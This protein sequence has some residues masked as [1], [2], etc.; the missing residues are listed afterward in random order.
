M[1][2]NITAIKLYSSLTD[3]V[4]ATSSNIRSKLSELGV[5]SFYLP[6]AID[7]EFYKPKSVKRLRARLN[8]KEDDI[9]LLYIGNITP[10]RFPSN[11]VLKAVKMLIKQGINIKF[12]I[13]A[14]CLSYNY[15][16]RNILFEKIRNF[17]LEQHVYFSIED[18]TEEEKANIYNIADIFI[19]PSLKPQAIDPPITVLEAMSCGKIVIASPIQSLTQIIN[20]RINGLLVH[21]LSKD[22]YLTLYTVCKD[23]DSFK[24][25]C[26][27][28]RQTILRNFSFEAVS[29][30]LQIL[31]SMLK[32]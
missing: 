26:R 31:H 5:K 7:T 10:T 15:T 25:I 28:A 19:F 14:P 16:Y 24:N 32:S 18:L 6:P 22:F 4:C 30:R 11:V 20:H 17:Q 27:N 29:R 13:Y 1:R 9:V 3:A 23:V 21:P 8:I 12:L 2:I